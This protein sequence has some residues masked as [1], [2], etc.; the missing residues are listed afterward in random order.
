MEFASATGRRLH[1]VSKPSAQW[2]ISNVWQD[3]LGRSGHREGCGPA[4]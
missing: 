1:Y 4:L 2:W 3:P